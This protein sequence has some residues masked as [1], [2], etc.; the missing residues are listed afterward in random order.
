MQIHGAQLEE[1]DL[2]VKTR[3]GLIFLSIVL[4]YNST[5]WFAFVHL[6]SFPSKALIARFFH[7]L[8]LF[9]LQS[10]RDNSLMPHEYNID[11]EESKGKHTVKPHIE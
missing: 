5:D 1:V 4:Y 3:A 6:C 10:E 11:Y 9:L 7:H 2:K 8:F